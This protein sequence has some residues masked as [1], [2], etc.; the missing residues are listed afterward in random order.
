MLLVYLL[1]LF[2]QCFFFVR[3][4]FY[5]VI[6]NYFNCKNL[7]GDTE[8]YLRNR[9]AQVLPVLRTVNQSG[10]PDREMRVIRLYAWIWIAGRLA[11]LSALAFI[12][13]PLVISY[14]KLVSSTLAAGYR[15]DA[16]AYLDTL[17][18][19]TL[20]ILPLL[21]GM[22]LWLWSLARSWGGL[23]RSTPS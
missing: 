4:D 18:M 11:A 20:A 1:S 17:V 23:V 9:M 8:G 3:T 6:A 5:Y 14:F 10:I 21:A 2:W 15:A 12:H 22:G 19:A 13:I 7:L 16:R